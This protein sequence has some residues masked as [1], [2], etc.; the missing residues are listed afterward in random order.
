[1]TLHSEMNDPAHKYYTDKAKDFFDGTVYL[2]M[3]YLYQ[4]LIKLI[5]EGG[6]ILD[7]G[8]GSGRD[9]LYFKKNGYNVI[10]F[11]YSEALVKLASD[12]IGSPVLHMSFQ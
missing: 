11:D 10:A 3:E 6:K 2:D 12:L 7:A 1:M 5:P 9:S 8:C 4:P